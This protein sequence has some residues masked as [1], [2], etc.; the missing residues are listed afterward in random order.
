MIKTIVSI[1]VCK[2]GVLHEECYGKNAMGYV[3]FP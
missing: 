2:Y 1:E 3:R